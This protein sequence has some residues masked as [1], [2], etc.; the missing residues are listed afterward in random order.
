MGWE[1]VRHAI[2][3]VVFNLTDAL[4]ASIGPFVIAL[5]LAGIVI[6]LGGVPMQVLAGQ[7][8]PDQLAFSGSAF[9]AIVGIL[10][11]YL[12]TFAWV[13]VTWHRFILLE[14]YPA[15]I[16]P[17]GGRPIWPYIG[18]SVGLALILVVIMIPIGI[19]A[20]LFVMPF[21]SSAPLAAGT[22]AGIVLGTLFT[23]FWLR[24]ALCLPA[25]AMGEEMG[26][27][28]AWGISGRASGGIFAAALILL[29]LNGLLTLPSG[30]I[31][32]NPVTALY[33]IAVTWFVLMV[34]ISMLTTLYGHLVQG[35]DLA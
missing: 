22:V 35:R 29:V 17:I 26:I 24:F 13:A 28:E 8:P 3:M 4:R 31:G 27:G 25:I 23:Y 30:L 5:L 11:I 18:R 2:R 6:T 16:P 15:M 34:G 7:V 21:V 9:L 19:V 12:F 20:S 14:E 10:L 33:D 32:P 1:L